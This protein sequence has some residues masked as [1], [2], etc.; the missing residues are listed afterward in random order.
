[1]QREKETLELELL[2]KDLELHSWQGEFKTKEEQLIEEQQQLERTYR[3]TLLSTRTELED[4][5]QQSLQHLKT[6][7][8]DGFER[9]LFEKEADFQSYHEEELSSLARQHEQQVLF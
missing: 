4:T 9:R 6:E 2:Q 7:L 3:D 1:M 8:E 5:Y